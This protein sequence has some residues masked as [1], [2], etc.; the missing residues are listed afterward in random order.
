MNMT[1]SELWTHAL[2]LCATFWVLFLLWIAQ[3]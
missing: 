1:R 3:S 2:G